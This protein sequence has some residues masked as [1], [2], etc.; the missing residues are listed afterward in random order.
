[1][2]KINTFALQE[3]IINLMKEQ[4]EDSR[5]TNIELGFTMCANTDN[6]I[7]AKNISK[8]TDKEIFISS[9]CPSGFKS[10]GSYH[11]HPDV[12]SRASAG[13][14]LNTCGHIGDCIGGGA[15]NKI[16]CYVRKKNVDPIDCTKEFSEH[17]SIELDLR[18]R[19]EDYERRRKLL[20][21]ERERIS[22]IE[23]RTR[24]IDI[25]SREIAKKMKEY[26]ISAIQSNKE[27]ESFGQ[28][29]L[30]LQNKYF[31]DIEIR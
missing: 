24:K 10:V 22:M 20:L 16:K 30:R 13:D 25:E 3:N 5:K 4:L 18:A 7:D 2:P 8:R 23:P 6:I 27:M 14:L 15:D 1:M 26:N 11:T 28:K 17:R 19:Y 31:D 29:L 12:I 9:D 21:K